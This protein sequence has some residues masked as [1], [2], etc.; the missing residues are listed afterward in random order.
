M[1]DENFYKSL[2]GEYRLWIARISLA[3]RERDFAFL[4]S[5]TCELACEYMGLN[6]QEV[7]DRATNLIK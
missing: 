1:Q 2:P 6:Y 7:Y 5:R 3:I 4:E